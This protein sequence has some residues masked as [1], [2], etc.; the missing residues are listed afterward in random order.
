MEK[1]VMVR[2]VIFCAGVAR[3]S[4]GDETRVH[5]AGLGSVG[6]LILWRGETTVNSDGFGTGRRRDFWHLFNLNV[7]SIRSWSR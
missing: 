4:T 1:G 2:S 5:V 7:A 3:L 6:R